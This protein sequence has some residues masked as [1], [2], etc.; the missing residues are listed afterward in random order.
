MQF[1]INMEIMASSAGRPH[2]PTPYEI[3]QE[4]TWNY[5]IGL[6]LIPVPL[7]EVTNL[8]LQD[9]HYFMATQ[10]DEKMESCFVEWDCSDKNLL[11]CT[12]SWGD[13]PN[14]AG[15]GFV[16]WAKRPLLW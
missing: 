13:E 2:P 7:P 9:V 14:K 16:S 8:C 10:K 1:P 15:S 5:V 6:K 11:V 3:S 12:W 4:I